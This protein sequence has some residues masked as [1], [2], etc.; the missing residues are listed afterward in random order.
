MSLLIADSKPAGS[1]AGFGQGNVRQTR[2][3]QIGQP[4]T[5]RKRGAE[6]ARH[7]GTD[8]R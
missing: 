1:Q 2:L 4:R 7:L 6:R 8:P 3:H 5:Q